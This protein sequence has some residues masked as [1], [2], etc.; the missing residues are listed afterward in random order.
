MTSV[1]LGPREALRQQ[2]S[3]GEGGGGLPARRTN[4]AYQWRV[5]WCL[6]MWRPGYMAWPYG[7]F[8]WQTD[9]A[10]EQRAVGPSMAHDGLTVQGRRSTGPR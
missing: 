6:A 2:A 7:A 9:D 3:T 4:P 8:C 1:E 10:A 5:V